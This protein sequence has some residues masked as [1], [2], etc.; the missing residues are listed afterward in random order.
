MHSRWRHI[1]SL[2][3]SNGLFIFIFSSSYHIREGISNLSITITIHK[4][5]FVIPHCLV[6]YHVILVFH[7]AREFLKEGYY[8]Q[9]EVWGLP[10]LHAHQQTNYVLPS[11]L[12]LH[13]HVLC[14]VEEQV[15]T[16]PQHLGEGKRGYDNKGSNNMLAIKNC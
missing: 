5:L 15:C 1:I 10:L 4:N 8:Q 16:H 14:D 3:D 13:T 7:I 2:C 12:F 6:S 9:E 11:H